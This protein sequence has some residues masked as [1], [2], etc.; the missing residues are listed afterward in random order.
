ML[1]NRDFQE[2]QDKQ[3]SPYQK[4]QTTKQQETNLFLSDR[5]PH[6]ASCVSQI[7]VPEVTV[8]TD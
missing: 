1:G 8:I 5:P 7:Q 2:Y 3:E 4:K 6:P